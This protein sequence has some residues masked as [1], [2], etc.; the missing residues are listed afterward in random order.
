VAGSIEVPDGTRWSVAGWLFYWTVR[1]IADE[2]GPGQVSDRLL[3]IDRE[4]LGDLRLNDFNPEDA[5]AIENVI[6]TKLQVRAQAEFANDYEGKSSA[7]ELLA[8][9]AALTSP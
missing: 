9:L 4:A 5:S 7:S 2:V 3:E 1:T 6:R 8:N